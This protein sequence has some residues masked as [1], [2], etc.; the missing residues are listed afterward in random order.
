MSA[1]LGYASA[2]NTERIHGGAEITANME[3]DHCMN[4]RSGHKHRLASSDWVLG[5]E[6]NAAG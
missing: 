6:L 4:I 3:P 5:T 2:V 1:L